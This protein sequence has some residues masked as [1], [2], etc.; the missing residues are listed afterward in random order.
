MWLLANRNERMKANSNLLNALHSIRLSQLN[1]TKVNHRLKRVL[2]SL[3]EMLQRQR[4]LRREVNF[5]I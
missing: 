1:Y 2:K 4:A 5:L 3:P